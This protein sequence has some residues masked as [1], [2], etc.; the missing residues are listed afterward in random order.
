MCCGS[1]STKGRRGAPQWRPSQLACA[2]A[3]LHRVHRPRSLRWAIVDAAELAHP[4]GYSRA[5]CHGPTKNTTHGLQDSHESLYSAR[6]LAKA[7]ARFRSTA[8]PPPQTLI[9]MDNYVGWPVGGQPSKACSDLCL[10]E[11][12]ARASLAIFLASLSVFVDRADLL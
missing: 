9:I 4:P 5:G 2:A 6:V 1:I 11:A 8:A 12:S 3:R 10:G 7:I